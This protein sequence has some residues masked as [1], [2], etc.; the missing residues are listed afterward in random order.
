MYIE[1]EKSSVRK[2]ILVEQVHV[3][4]N[5]GIE[6]AQEYFGRKYVEMEMSGMRTNILVEWYVEMEV[7]F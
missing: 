1:M 6:S 5:G 3:R 2:N 4:R 7:V